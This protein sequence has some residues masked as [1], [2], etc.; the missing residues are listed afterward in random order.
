MMFTLGVRVA[1]RPF[2][3]TRRRSP[4][5]LTLLSYN[6]ITICTTKSL[7]QFTTLAGFQLVHDSCD[8]AST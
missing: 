5:C 8:Y 6:R 1:G 7:H 4:A 3:R 2:N